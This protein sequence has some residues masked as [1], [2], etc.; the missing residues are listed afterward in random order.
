M[1]A[2]KRKILLNIRAVWVQV[3]INKRFNN[4]S[5]H[6][7]CKKEFLILCFAKME[8]V[9]VSGRTEGKLLNEISQECWVRTV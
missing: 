9:V 7:K 1:L 8:S 2:N 6:L 3:N 5:I 4:N